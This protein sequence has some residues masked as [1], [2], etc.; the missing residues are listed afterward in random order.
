MAGDPLEPHGGAWAGGGIPATRRTAALQ[1]SGVLSAA[2]PWAAGAGPSAACALEGEEP[3]QST[4]DGEGLRRD[5]RR[6]PGGR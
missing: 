4:G 1:S 2:V 6:G 5:A 3:R